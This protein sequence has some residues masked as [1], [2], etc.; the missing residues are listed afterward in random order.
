MAI[1]FILIGVSVIACD[2]ATVNLDPVGDTEAA[3]FLNE[4][5]MT[6]GVFGIY[7]KLTWFYNRGAS[8]DNTLQSVWML[9]SD[10]LTS[11]GNF[12]TEI[13]STL[14][15]SDGKMSR[16][17]T[18]SYQLIS[19]ANIVLEKIAE[20]GSFAYENAEL[21]ENHRGE[22]LFLRSLMY[23]NLWNIFGTAPLVVE[24]IKTL[25]EA[26]PPNSTGTQL[27]DQAITDLTEAATLLPD[28][29][30]AGNA[31][32]ATANSAR[33]LLGKCLVFRGTVNNTPADFT[34]AIAAINAITGR[35]L[36]PNFNDNFSGA[37]ENN[38]ES[39]FEFQAN[40]PIGGVNP[41]VP[42]G[43]DGFDVIGELNAFWG[44]FNGVGVD[45]P[46]QT[47]R[48][49]ESLKSAFELGD[50]RIGY[51]VNMA[52]NASN[53]NNVRKYTLNPAPV[54]GNG[55][56]A[57]GLQLAANN[58]RILR[59]ADVLLLKAEAIV[60]SNGANGTLTDAITL[61]NQVRARARTSGG[62]S[63]VPADLATPAD[64]PTAL[65]IIFNERRVELAFEEGHR[66]FD[67]RRRHIAGEIDL[68]TWDFDAVRT[69]FEFKATNINFPLP[70][71]EILQSP[72]LEQN[73][74]Y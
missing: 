16:Y 2:E 8:G 52:V 3:Y 12:S 18:L 30:D 71:V 61:V 20:N 56:F 69:D 15:G 72:N 11:T 48:A 10:D 57:E 51:S 26:Y 28:A 43:N 70:E 24:R 25:N 73:S 58:P 55:G 27:L 6:M 47:Y 7:A 22:A 29:W 38:V 23:F 9:P 60:R 35:S 42:E 33:G 67:L 45:A 19:R 65:N 41:W 44:I 50:P 32:R 17:Y 49:T 62:V 40:Q 54:P 39:L 5:Q 36:T 46:T 64:A 74:G 31:G 21:A 34:A 68:T 4:N 59:Y 13:F 63:L 14:K 37:M 53:G 1:C 66:W